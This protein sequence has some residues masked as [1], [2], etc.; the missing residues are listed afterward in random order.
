MIKVYSLFLNSI[1]FA[2]K[3]RFFAQIIFKIII[4]FIKLA[5]L[6]ENQKIEKEKFS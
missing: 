4:M 5:S 6:I 2:D 1:V 3:K